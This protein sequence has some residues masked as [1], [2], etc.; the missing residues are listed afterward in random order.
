MSDHASDRTL[1]ELHFTHRSEAAAFVAAL[2]RFLDSPRGARYLVPPG[3]AEVWSHAA[4]PHGAV[5]VYLNAAALAAATAAFAP[6]IVA[7]TRKAA[8]LPANGKLMI[9][10]AQLPVWGLEEAERVLAELK[11]EG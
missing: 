4:H 2:S 7:G 8:E 6:V 11:A 9:G 1:H 10:A 5:D 3:A